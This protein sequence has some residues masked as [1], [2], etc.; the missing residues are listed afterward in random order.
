[1]SQTRTLFS[2]RCEID[3]GIWLNTRRNDLA[4]GVDAP[5][6]GA[7]HRAHRSEYY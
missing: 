3:D 4:L 1:M 5:D 7:A 6:F 2:M